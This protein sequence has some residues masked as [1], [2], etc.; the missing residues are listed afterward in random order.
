MRP[1]ESKLASHGWENNMDSDFARARAH[2][3]RAHKF[4]QGNDEASRK[5]AEA[6]DLLVINLAAAECASFGS[7]LPF[8]RSELAQD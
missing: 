8:H 7:F 4:L 1:I 2:L 5:A 6:I 3:K